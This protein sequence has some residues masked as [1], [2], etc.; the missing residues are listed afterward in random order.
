DCVLRSVGEM[1]GTV[2]SGI[3]DE[4]TICNGARSPHSTHRIKLAAI[5]TPFNSP[6]GIDYHE[7]SDTVIVSVNYS[8]GLPYDF[9]RINRD[10]THVQF[11]TISNLTEEVK[12]A[13]VQPGNVGGFNV[14]EL[15]CGNGLDGQIV[16]I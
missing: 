6:N 14:G 13:T 3:F 7:P 11:S 8:S 4:R 12:I 16:R 5:S 15:F 10:G 1:R 2:L 9:E